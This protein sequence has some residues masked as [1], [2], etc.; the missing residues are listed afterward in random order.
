M[1]RRSDHGGVDGGAARRMVA[2]RGRW[3]AVDRW[4]ATTKG[5]DENLER[6]AVTGSD[7]KVGKKSK[8]MLKRRKEMTRHVDV[9]GVHRRTGKDLAAW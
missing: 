9:A 5:S 8:I 6:G 7:E 2:W 4:G 3:R 1:Q